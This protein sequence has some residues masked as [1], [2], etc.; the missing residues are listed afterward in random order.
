MS[1]S[2]RTQV[3]ATATETQL[4]S[5]VYWAAARKELLPHTS[6]WHHSFIS[7]YR[8]ELELRSTMFCIHVRLP[9]AEVDHCINQFNN[10]KSE[11]LFMWVSQMCDSSAFLF[12]S[13]KHFTLSNINIQTR[14]VLWGHFKPCVTVR[15]MIFRCFIKCYTFTFPNNLPIHSYTLLLQS[16]TS[17][18]VRHMPHFLK[19]EGLL[20]WIWFWP[21]LLNPI[22]FLN[23]I[24]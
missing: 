18:K 3:S 2:G 22:H 5:Q 12:S 13:S 15:K 1:V 14:E 16:R 6:F 9:D 7:S 21:Q 19:V 4:W 20:F 11:L 17:L 24:F 10:R 8:P 23:S